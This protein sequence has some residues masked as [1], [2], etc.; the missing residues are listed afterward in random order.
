MIGLSLVK[1]AR[2]FP[3]ETV[4]IV[5]RLL[6]GRARSWQRYDPIENAPPILASALDSTD[7]IANEAALTLMDR[8]DRDGFTDLAEAVNRYRSR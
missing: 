5:A 1:A 3:Q 7:A 6:D 2:D 8:V 4:Q